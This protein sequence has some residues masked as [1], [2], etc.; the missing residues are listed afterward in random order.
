MINYQESTSLFHLQSVDFSYVL[1][2]LENG[3]LVHRYFG[4]KV[5][6]FSRDNKITYLDRAFSPNP[7]SKDRTFSLDTLPLEYSSNGLGD[8]RTSAIELRNEKGTSLDLRYK[9]HRIFVGKKDLVGLPAS[10]G[11]DEEVETLEIDL[12]D[13]LIDVT[14][15]LTYS[16]FS[17]ANYLTRS[18]LIQTGREATHIEKALSMTLDLPHKDFTIHTLT[19]RYGYEKEWTRTPLTQGKYSVGSIRG[20]SSHSRTPFI[21]LADPDA[22]ED[23]GEIYTAQLVYSGNFIAFA[24]TTALH[25]TRLGIGLN[26]E[27]FN[28]KLEAYS[29]F[30]APEALLSYTSK[31][32]TGLT[33]DSQNF[34]RHHLVRGNWAHK[35]RPI[36][37]NNWEATY[38]DFTEEKIVDLA[39]SAK[40]TGI[41]LFVLDDG[42]FGKRN[43]DT[44]SLGDWVENRQKLPSGLNGLAK[45]ITDLGMKFGLWFEPEMVSE[46][47]DLYRA[48]PD[49][50]IQTTGRSHTYS[51][52]QLV[53]DLSK[54]EVCDY[55]IESVSSV[56]QS[57][58][59]SYVKWDMNRNITNI[60]ELQANHEKHEFYHR[61]ILG[62]YRVLETLHQRFPEILFE[63][64][65]GG[66][67]RNDLGLLYY[68]PQAWA[69]D[70]TDA[71]GRL[72]IQDGTGLIFP[73]IA[74]GSHVSAVPNHQ[75]GRI[76][77]LATR[78]NVAM[79]GNLGYELDLHALTKDD[80]Q[81][82][83][84]EVKNYKSIRHTV[85]FGDYYR[86]KKTNNTHAYN[87]VN[88][89]KSQVVFTFIKILSQP[90][91]PLLHV[92]L[93]GLDEKAL[94]YSKELD[95][96]FYGD[97]LMN[98]GLTM[99]HIQKDYFSVQYIFHKQ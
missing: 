48:H 15:T 64:C 9:D 31:G 67:G 20:A 78:G 72:S 59:I 57:A 54:D 98:I 36:L 66:G 43:S 88:E 38:F 4:K 93:K 7:I 94:Y 26:D 5:N 16:L 22:S 91:A 47:S 33:K 96:S 30:Q 32:F 18:A 61:Y 52:E 77:S 25:T 51:R 34:V 35:E 92:K 74:V 1:Q 70:N 11:G 19:G 24:E 12:Y 69:S 75:T 21:A 14:V 63:S 10:F 39:K 40:E 87:Y 55:L 41:E 53:L 71:I 44:C 80:L 83:E 49:W 45:K 8:F 17:R 89:D 23:A 84:Q 27:K 60:P 82:I 58:N 85:Q 3:L 29:S 46:D 68:M 97:E 28:W 79:L 76:T 90:E 73:S 62:L 6:H 86:L 99:P 65:S 81:E 50:T 37:I 2:V 13:E 42:W 56:L 95:A